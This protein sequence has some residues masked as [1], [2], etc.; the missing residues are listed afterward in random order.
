LTLDCNA[1]GS[2]LPKIA[3][4]F[5]SNLLQRDA[6]NRFLLANASA[7]QSGKYSCEAT[8]SAGAVS[9]DFY[10]EVMI[11]PRIRSYEK[12]VNAV[13]GEKAKLECKFEGNPEPTV[14]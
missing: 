13:E 10:V 1:Q 8:N 7:A 4:Y 5:G 6:G 11:K 12:V 14:K 9:A 3:W 2:P